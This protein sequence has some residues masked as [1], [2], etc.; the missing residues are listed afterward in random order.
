MYKKIV[1]PVDPEH[2][3]SWR[4]TVPIAIQHARQS[5]GELLVT[6]VVPEI[7]ANLRRTNESHQKA[8]DEFV[9]DNIP[10]DVTTQAILKKGSIHR[11][12]CTL[13][14]QTNADL[15]IVASQNPRMKDRIV[16]S[17]AS[18]IAQYAPCNVL[19]VRVK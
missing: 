13:A 2:D 3:N 6:T 4:E 5:G 14:K 11:E 17:N 15:I 9:K 7:E 18:N 12:I 8:L 16:G 1:V 10:E 19:V